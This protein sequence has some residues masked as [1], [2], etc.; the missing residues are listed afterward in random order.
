MKTATKTR[1]FQ[2]GLVKRLQDPEYALGFLHLAFELY[3]EDG[4]LAPLLLAIK[5]VAKAHEIKS[6][7]E[8]MGIKRE[9]L[10]RSLSENGNPSFQ[11]V[12]DVLKT[13]GL[14]LTVEVRGAKLGE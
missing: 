3:E 14:R 7:S 2:D 9:S 8:Q 13:M 5:R 6:L 1:T 4:E 12:A 11:R 10:S